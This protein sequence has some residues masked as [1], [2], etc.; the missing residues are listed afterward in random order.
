MSDLRFYW[1]IDWMNEYNLL[2]YGIKFY[3]ELIESVY[4]TFQMITEFL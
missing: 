4:V 1:L 3:L 2:T